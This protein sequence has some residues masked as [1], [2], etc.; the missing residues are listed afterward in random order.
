MEDR[1][2]LYASSKSEPSVAPFVEISSQTRRISMLGSR[3]VEGGYVTEEQLQ[4]AID[5]QKA[6]GGL[7]G[8]ALIALGS[9]TQAQLDGFF[10]KDQKSLSGEK[11]VQGGL[12][13]SA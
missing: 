11:M 13:T 10:A 1:E 12:L 2:N 8:N 7:L 3:L 4:A 6:H 5:Y 9:L